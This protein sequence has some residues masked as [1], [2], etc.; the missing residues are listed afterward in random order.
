MSEASDEG[1]LRGGVVGEGI[2]DVKRSRYSSTYVFY[3]APFASVPNVPSP[4]ISVPI[5]VLIWTFNS[6]GGG[7]G[8]M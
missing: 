7:G 6:R 8:G 3:S 1:F 4:T 5:S 2:S